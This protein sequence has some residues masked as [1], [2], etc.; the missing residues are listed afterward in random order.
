MTDREMVLEFQRLSLD[1][2][3]EL[4]EAF[5]RVVREKV[6]ETEQGKGP[7]APKLTRGMLRPD[8]PIPTD[9]ELKEDYTNY[10]IKKYL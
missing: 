1:K 7:P 6:F 10:V 3:L 5:T 4:L 9:G 8:G 2:Q